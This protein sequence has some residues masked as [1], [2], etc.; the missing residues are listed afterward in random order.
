M[1]LSARQLKAWSAAWW[2]IEPI[3]WNRWLNG[4][5]C[6]IGD[7]HGMR[8]L[9]FQLSKDQDFYQTD[10]PYRKVLSARFQSTFSD[11][12]RQLFAK[13]SQCLKQT[14]FSYISC[15]KNGFNSSIVD[16]QPGEAGTKKGQINHESTQGRKHQKSQ[17]NFVL[18]KFRVFV[19]K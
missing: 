16:T 2:R 12:A 17:I 13:S 10:Q 19:M 4:R 6:V 11:G 14:P 18:S 5:R 9:H 8:C 3:W 7:L 15:S 1:L